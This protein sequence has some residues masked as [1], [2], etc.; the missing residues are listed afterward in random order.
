M[1]KLF[2]RPRLMFVSVLLLVV[3]LFCI[4]TPMYTIGSGSMEP[5]LP[6]GT[7]VIVRAASVDDLHPQDIITFQQKGDDRPTTHTFIGKDSD[8]NVMTKGDANPTPDVHVKPL[9]EDDIV[10]K[11]VYAIFL[12]RLVAVILI[13]AVAICIVPRSVDDKEVMQSKEADAVA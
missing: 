3:S 5:T 13:V 11:V 1:K 8:G 2:H 7:I 4:F 6:V 9:T 10:G 12:R